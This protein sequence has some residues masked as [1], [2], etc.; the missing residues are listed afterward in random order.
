MTFAST[1]RTETTGAK[2]GRR[3][4]VVDDNKDFVET[5]SGVA[6]TE[7]ASRRGRIRR[8]CRSRGCHPHGAGRCCARC[9]APQAERL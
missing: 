7:R 8:P 6:G 2:T 1:A 3:F 5:T 4:L 9:W